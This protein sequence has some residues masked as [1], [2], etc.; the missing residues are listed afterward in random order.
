MNTLLRTTPVSL[1]KL[2]TPQKIPIITV[3]ICNLIKNNKPQTQLTKVYTNNKLPLFL[4]LNT[5]LDH[6]QVKRNSGYN[7]IT[8]SKRGLRLQEEAQDHHHL[9]PYNLNNKASK[10][11]LLSPKMLFIIKLEDKFLII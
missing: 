3:L 8:M 7:L 1:K 9:S 4:L 11:T 5:S 10:K 6:N 2:E